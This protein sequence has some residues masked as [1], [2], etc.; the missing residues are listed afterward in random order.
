MGLGYAGFG[1]RGISFYLSLLKHPFTGFASIGVY[2]DTPQAGKR[3]V[4][5]ARAQPLPHL[6]GSCPG[7][8]EVVFAQRCFA[9]RDEDAD[10]SFKK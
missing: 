8:T 9:L 7:G 4:T 3:P 5:A 10:Q 2:A 1:G 6:W